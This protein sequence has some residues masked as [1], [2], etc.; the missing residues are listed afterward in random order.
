MM[1]D[2]DNICA[3]DI[4]GKGW[5]WRSAGRADT[6]VLP[7][8]PGTVS[9]EIT[10]K[11]RGSSVVRKIDCPFDVTCSSNRFELT[12]CTSSGN[13]ASALLSDES[14]KIVERMLE[15]FAL[16]AIAEHVTRSRLE[17]WRVTALEG[18]PP[19]E[20]ESLWDSYLEA[21]TAITWSWPAIDWAFLIN[22]NQAAE[23]RMAI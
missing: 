12:P 10:W 6:R 7:L 22:E 19:E 20:L 16:I 1:P 14:T 9:F 21:E 11:S 23:L 15:G 8:G 2:P 3:Y 18:R 4:V 17:L 5:L 13:E